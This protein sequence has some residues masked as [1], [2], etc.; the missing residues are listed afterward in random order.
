M[1]FKITAKNG[2]FFQLSACHIQGQVTLPCTPTKG[3]QNKKQK[4]V[5]QALAVTSE[6]PGSQ[7]AIISPHLEWNPR[8]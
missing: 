3:K 8:E 4:R 5:A 6:R 1:H 7:G 2:F